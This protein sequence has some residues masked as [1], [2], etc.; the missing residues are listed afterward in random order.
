[1]GNAEIGENCLIEPGVSITSASRASTHPDGVIS[2]GAGTCVGAG[3]VLASGVRIGINVRIDAGAFVLRDVPSFAIV[4]GNPARIIGYNSHE[5][6]GG[7]V[8]PDVD[9]GSET[10]AFRPCTVDGVRFYKFPMISDA[11]GDLTVAEFGPDFPF[12]VKRYFV[13]LNVPAAANRGEHAHWKCQEILVCLQGSLVVVVD[14]G[15]RS[16]EIELNDPT[17]GLYLPPM[18]WRTQHSYSSS[19]IVLAL[20][21]S[22][23][24]TSDYIRDYD[25]FLTEVRRGA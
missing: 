21:S 23:Y 11:R 3:S 18:V 6:V 9:Q 20:A 2:V 17:V 15:T 19:C 7:L 14:D 5:V 24:D 16:Q 13:V 22:H 10:P 8:K 1:M 25:H 12:E 4:S